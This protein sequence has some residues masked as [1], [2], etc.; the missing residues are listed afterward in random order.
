MVLPHLV[1]RV[2]IILHLYIVDRQRIES[3]YPFWQ[4][5]AQSVLE[6]VNHVRDTEKRDDLKS[7]A[8]T[9]SG[10]LEKKLPT[11]KDDG[12]SK[13][14][15][16]PSSGAGA[17]AGAGTGAGASAAAT[18]GASAAPAPAS[19]D[20]ESKRTIAIKVGVRRGFS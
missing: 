16:K 19:K 12:A 5:H 18:A 9:F 3:V 2:L 13:P 1:W 11:L 7:V 20:A 4:E 10:M 17:G 6:K 8:K 14:K 15:P